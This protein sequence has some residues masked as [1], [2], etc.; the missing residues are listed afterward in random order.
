MNFVVERIDTRLSTLV[1]KQEEESK[2]IDRVLGE[3]CRAYLTP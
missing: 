3:K 2:I 1:H